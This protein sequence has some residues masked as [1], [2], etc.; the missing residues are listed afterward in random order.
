MQQNSWKKKC[1]RLRET[2]SL[3][4]RAASRTDT[5]QLLSEQLLW[6]PCKHQL[7]SEASSTVQLLND[8]FES[9]LT[10]RAMDLLITR[11]ETP[12]LFTLVRGKDTT[13][14]VY[15]KL[16]VWKPAREYFTSLP[17]HRDQQRAPALQDD[18]WQDFGDSRRC[19]N[20]SRSIARCHSI[21]PRD[22]RQHCLADVSLRED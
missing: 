19:S 9:P 11:L 17:R 16:C 10:C 22:N 18:L 3:W 20:V 6:I 1:H 5:S 14:E 7:Q 4:P 2:I 12:Y 21:L 8:A 13:V 15:Q